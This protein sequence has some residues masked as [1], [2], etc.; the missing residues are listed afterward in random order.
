MRPKLRLLPKPQRLDIAASI[1]ECMAALDQR[2]DRLAELRLG[3]MQTKA[4]IAEVKATL[5]RIGEFL[6]V[7]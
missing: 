4:R 1:D 7:D 2:N 6:Q 3:I 5:R